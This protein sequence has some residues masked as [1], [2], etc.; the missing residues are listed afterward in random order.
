MKNEELLSRIG[1]NKKESQIYLTLLENGGMTIA[2][3]S[4]KSKINRPA[5]YKLL[6]NLQKLGLVVNTP[7]GKQTHYVAES[8]KKLRAL[9]DGLKDSFFELLPDLENTYEGMGYKPIVKFFIGKEGIGHVFMDVVN[10]LSRGETYYRYTA[11]SDIKKINKYMPAEFKKIREQKA[12]EA[13]IISTQA[14]AEAGKRNIHRVVKTMPEEFDHFN[15]DITIYIYGDKISFIDFNTD[16]AVI[17]ENK[18]IAEF[19]RKIFQ[20]VY[21]KL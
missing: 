1:L 9:I 16:T 21:R 6:P 7:Y 19:Q 4:H 17:I 12:L 2:G 18:K 15:Q 10:T 13:V 20:F 11:G 8:P 14:L 3:I 5:V